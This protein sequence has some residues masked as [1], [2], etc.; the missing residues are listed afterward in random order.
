MFEKAVALLKRL[1]QGGDWPPSN[2]IFVRDE[3]FRLM[4]IL[5]YS[6]LQ[7][8]E[9]LLA[10]PVLISSCATKK[11]QNCSTYALHRS[12]RIIRLDKNID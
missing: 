11:S 3:Y 1:H 2:R 5:E 10:A 4:A 12:V 6:Y 8:D 9:G 7:K